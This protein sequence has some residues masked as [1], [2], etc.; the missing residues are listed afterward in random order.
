[1]IR[2]IQRI[3]LAALLSIILVSCASV[4]TG[5]K[6]IQLGMTKSEV[7]SKMGENY[8]LV[9]MTQ[10]QEGYL[11]VIRYTKYVVQDGRSVPAQ[12]YYIQ[13]LNGKL[14]EL[15]QEDAIRPPI[16]RQVRQHN[17]TDEQ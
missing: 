7:V 9:S 17:T 13:F 2:F 11:E 14:I 3:L 1:M 6:Q 8:Q 16:I 5:V 15:Q 12:H 10:I 4:Q